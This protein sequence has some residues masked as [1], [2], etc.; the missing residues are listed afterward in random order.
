MFHLN[1]ELTADPYLDERLEGLILQRAGLL[2][3]VVLAVILASGLAM[4]LVAVIVSEMVKT[5]SRQLL[6]DQQKDLTE[7]VIRRLDR[8]FLEGKKVLSAASS[9]LVEDNQLLP[10]ERLQFMLDNRVFLHEFFNGGLAVL[11]A[12]GTIIGDSPTLPGRIGT[13]TGN[14][15][16]VEIVAQTKQPH[17]SRP[18]VGLASGLPVFIINAPIL[19]PEDELVGFLFGITR[20]AEDNMIRQIAR[21]IFGT[22]GELYIIDANNARVVTST[23]EHL[24]HLPFSQASASSIFNMVAQGQKSGLASF[25]NGEKVM[26]SSSKFEQMDW[27]VIYTQPYS[28]VMASVN[29]ILLNIFTLSFFFLLVVAIAILA[30]MN[31]LLKPLKVASDRIEQMVSGQIKSKR[32]PVMRKDE[33]GRL[34]HAFNRL[35]AKQ[36]R[37]AGQLEKSKQAAEKANQAKSEFLAN[38]SHEIRT[39][40]NGIIG[41]CE[42][43]LNERNAHNLKQN[44][45][46]IYQSGRLLLTIINDIL[47]FSKIEAKK[48]EI[49]NHP[50]FLQNL[51]DN[52][53]SLYAHMAEEKGLKLVFKQDP[54]LAAAYVGD[55]TR[56]RQVLTNLIGNAIKFTHHGQVTV[57]VDVVNYEQKRGWVHFS[58]EDT[59]IGMN[60]MQQANLFMAFNQADTSITRQY[61]GTGLGLIISQRLVEAMGGEDIFI[62]TEPGK[63]SV[64][65]FELPLRVASPTEQ[66]D[67]LEHQSRNIDQRLA[68][69]GHVLLVE[70]NKINQEVAQKQLKQMGLQVTLVENG[71]LAVEAMQDSNN[72]FDLILMDIQMPVMDG[73]QASQ[74]IRAFNSQIP[75]VA[76]TAAAMV[77]DRHKAIEAGMTGHLGKPIDKDDLYCTLSTWLAT[78][79]SRPLGLD[80]FALNLASDHQFR[81]LDIESGIE[82]LCGDES[83]YQQLLTEL[84]Q[85]IEQEYLPLVGQLTSLSPQNQDQQAW[86]SMASQLHAL[87]GMASNLAAKNLASLCGELNQTLKQASP[88]TGEQLEQF[89][90]ELELVTQEIKDYL[91]ENQ[92]KLAKTKVLLAEDNRVN[93]IVMSKQLDKLGVEY[94]LAKDGIEALEWL[95]K[96]V[97]DLVLMD[98]EMPKLNGLEATKAWRNKADK[99]QPMIIALTANQADDLRESC[100]EAGMDDF[101]EKPLNELK[102]KNLIQNNVLS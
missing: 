20:L 99:Y 25:P 13:F 7:I 16:H 74:R 87:K 73:Y 76:L 51:L 95:D 89:N 88:P 57:R 10:A 31:V 32:L 28:M 35:M 45:F 5:E 1:I 17:I 23:L 83:H 59:G 27:D 100:L 9:H 50:F 53:A 75:I 12:S 84:G 54:K 101:I 64:F 81:S 15:P 72:H 61:G 79:K 98:I 66:G 102:L 69:M 38:M 90:Q 44:L 36:A 18:L 71:K 62:N 93:Q 26:F 3:R 37:Q 92:Q 94:D 11:D 91:A 70:D 49:Y 58:V 34:V 21:E 77:E 43:S 2:N 86:L 67:L 56:L 80:D 39:P 6:L 97:Y 85:Q 78:D 8:T 33:V 68:L 42:L 19:T 24:A 40:M 30:W 41:L 65:S 63:G 29:S 14:L 96:K 22:K 47:D 4:L 82:Q 52:L 55:E 60:S 48:M 46:K